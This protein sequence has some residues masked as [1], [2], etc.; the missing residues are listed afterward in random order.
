MISLQHVTNYTQQLPTGAGVYLFYQDPKLLP[1]YIGKSINI[2]KRVQSHFSAAKRDDKEQC[3]I[4]KTHFIDFKETAGELGALLLEAQLVKQHLPVH[5]RKLR[6]HKK[7]YSFIVE[8]N[9]GHLQ[10]R[11]STQDT[12]NLQLNDQH[13][14]LF[15][16]QR[17]AQERIDSII[18]RQ[19]LCKKSLGL[20]KMGKTCFAYQLKK[21][22]G[23]CANEESI[24][25]HNARFLGAMENFRQQVWP[26]NHPIGLIEQRDNFCDVHIINNWCYIGTLSKGSNAVN[27][28]NLSFDIDIYNILRHSLHYDSALQ[29]MHCTTHNLKAIVEEVKQTVFKS[30]SIA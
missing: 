27:L 24:D 16:N 6:R 15:R 12:Q 5:N 13:Y 2:R 20:E 7:I 28:P 18:N 25:E 9:K 26:F 3:I 21:C 22:K 30:S 17:R 8:N 23:V 10:P 11:L 29:L 19:Q 14:G 1:V 4:S